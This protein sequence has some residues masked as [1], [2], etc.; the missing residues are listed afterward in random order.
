ML[1]SSTKG[2][3]WGMLA[4]A[5]TGRTVNGGVQMETNFIYDEAR[6]FEVRLQNVT[7]EDVVFDR[8]LMSTASS[9][10]NT[11]TGAGWVRCLLMGN[12]FIVNLLFLHTDGSSNPIVYVADQVK[13]FLRRSFDLV[14]SGTEK[15]DIDALLQDFYNDKI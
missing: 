7:G 15:M 9:N 11:A 13:D 6:P 12:D 8:D 4:C 2:G 5:I 1:G 3:D 10:P 14:P